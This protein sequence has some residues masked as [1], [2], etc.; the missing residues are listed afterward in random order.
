[1]RAGVRSHAE[2]PKGSGRRP[3]LN[4]GSRERRT[5]HRRGTPFRLISDARARVAIDATKL[6]FFIR[7]LRT[8]DVPRLEA[9]MINPAVKGEQ[10]TQIWRIQYMTKSA[11]H[12]AQERQPCNSNHSDEQ[13]PETW[14][15]AGQVRLRQ[16]R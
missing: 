5:R 6:A 4:P 12:A 10:H 16:R 11:L 15:L 14:A 2:A 1:M 3:F 7:G 8:Q 13:Y 9:L